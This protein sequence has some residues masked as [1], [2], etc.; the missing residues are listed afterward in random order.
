MRDAEKSGGLAEF[1]WGEIDA[2]DLGEVVVP[3]DPDDPTVV[4]EIP[5]R[6]VVIVGAVLI[7]ICAAFIAYGF[8]G[9]GDSGGDDGDDPGGTSGERPARTASAPYRVTDTGADTGAG[10]HT[11]RSP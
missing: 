3:E 8:L 4:G 11:D 2:G 6:R 9:G 10:P 5:D 1:G 7:G